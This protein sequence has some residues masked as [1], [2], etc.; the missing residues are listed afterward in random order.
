ML[1]PTAHEVYFAT[2][3]SIGAPLRPC[4]GEGYELIK[5]L[6]FVVV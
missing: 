6:Y 5:F 1:F 3:M 2:A 4:A